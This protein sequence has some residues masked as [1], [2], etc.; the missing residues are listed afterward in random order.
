V[1]T[2]GE[3]RV[4]R[5]CGRALAAPGGWGAAAPDWASVSEDHNLARATL[6]D[7]RASNEGCTAKR[8]TANRPNQFHS[9]FPLPTSEAAPIILQPCEGDTMVTSYERSANSRKPDA[10][11]RR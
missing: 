2:A 3:A 5:G 11:S 7:G 1:A 9:E 4:R 6:G 8:R 10:A